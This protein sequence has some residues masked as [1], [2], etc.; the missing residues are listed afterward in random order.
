MTL[1]CEKEEKQLK[2]RFKF[3]AIMHSFE[4][5]KA[6]LF[7]YRI[8]MSASIIILSHSFH[9]MMRINTEEKLTYFLIHAFIRV[10]YTTQLKCHS[11]QVFLKAKR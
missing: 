1:H 11:L 9:L 6:W 3:G 2:I 4:Y 7:S 5:I 8:K 10:S